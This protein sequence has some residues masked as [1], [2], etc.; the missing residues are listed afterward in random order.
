MSLRSGSGVLTPPPEI[1]STFE[2]LTS[3]VTG[4]I[5]DQ[6]G[7]LA[8]HVTTTV[9]I[10][11]LSTFLTFFFLLDAD[12]G[13]EWAL[14]G[15]PLEERAPLRDRGHDAA[16]RVGGFVRATAAASAIRS[17]A[18]LVVMLV[19]GTPFAGPLAVV[20][21]VG[22][23]IPYLGVLV[24][25]LAI[26]LV[27]LG[28]QGFGPAVLVLAAAF[29]I[30]GALTYGRIRLEG[31]LGLRV[32][33]AI[34]LLALPIGAL[35]A[36]VIGMIVAVPVAAFLQLMIGPALAAFQPRLPRMSSTGPVIPGWLDRLAHWC[37]GLLVG[38]VL[39][40]GLV[41][42]AIQLWAPLLAV[43]LAAV[44]AAT[45]SPA[46]SPSVAAEPDQR[47]LRSAPPSA[48][49]PVSASS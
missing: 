16:L 25:T 34:A 29:G 41:L 1:A 35:A 12:H 23:L 24:S 32:H 49:S 33:P 28:G 45:L 3:V 4:F 8:G 13:A 39:L 40:G 6:L 22:G 48:W 31:S 20:L 5:Q 2:H 11:V 30:E 43:V 42:L 47:R 44:L 37:R 26:V 21:L 46:A 15:V 27:A 7:A 14:Q 36:G 9:T 38:V 10:A 18:M 19:L 17:A